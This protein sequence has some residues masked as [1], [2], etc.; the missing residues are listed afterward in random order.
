MPKRISNKT[1]KDANQ[2]AFAVVN[3]STE[4]T[5]G[6]PVAPIIDF[7]AVMREMGRRGGKIGGKR[8]LQTMTKAERRKRAQ[9]AARRRWANKKHKP[10]TK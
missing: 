5:P 4:E 8:S 6:A 9:K 1:P 7:S 2:T 3:L 10:L